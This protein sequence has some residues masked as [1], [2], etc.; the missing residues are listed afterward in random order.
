MTPNF[1]AKIAALFAL[2]LAGALAAATPAK[3]PAPGQVITQGEVKAEK[4]VV[5]NGVSKV[6][7]VAAS[8]V[9]PGDRLLF[10]TVYRNTAT[11]PATNFTVTN[12]V[13]AAVSVTPESAAA[14]VVS[15]DGGTA[16]GRLAAL[17]VA[18]GK[19]GRRPALAADVTHVRWTIASIPPGA[20]GRV[21]YHAVVR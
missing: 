5:E 20:S 16:W 21:E 11:V 12:P 10:A 8:H 3:A 17:T 13:P 15:V 6:Q 18:D 4:T 7:L 14:L 9:L 1:F 19:G 2:T